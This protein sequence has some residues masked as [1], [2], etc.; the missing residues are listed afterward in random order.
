MDRLQNRA[1]LRQRQEAESGLSF[2]IYDNRGYVGY[3]DNPDNLAE[4]EYLDYQYDSDELSEL[5]YPSSP[6]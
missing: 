3:Q 4:I 2:L 1:L 5:A 6:I